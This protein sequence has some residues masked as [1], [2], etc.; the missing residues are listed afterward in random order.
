MNN[1]KRALHHKFPEIGLAM[2]LHSVWP[3]L[4][5]GAVGAMG[6]YQPVANTTGIVF[7]RYG[8]G[9]TVDEFVRQLGGM[10]TDITVL[11]DK[12]IT[13]AGEDGRRVTVRM[14]MHLRKPVER[15]TLVVI[16]FSHRGIPILV[17]YRVLDKALRRYQTQ[18]EGIF[19]SVALS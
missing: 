7:V 18:L 1:K 12:P 6:I 15:T 9:E 8:P 11:H 2:D 17:G 3:V 16:G 14:T 5:L 19:D 10:L 13:F 4:S